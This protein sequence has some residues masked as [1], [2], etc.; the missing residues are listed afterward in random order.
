MGSFACTSTTNDASPAKGPSGPPIGADQVGGACSNVGTSPGDVVAFEHE[1]CPAGLCVADARDGFTSYCTADCSK[2]ACPEGYAC[3]AETLGDGRK[4]CLK[5]GSPAPGTDAGKDAAKADAG[6]IGTKN[7]KGTK[8]VDA[9][10]STKGTYTCDG[11]CQKAG[12]KCNEK[13]AGNGVGW[14][15]RKYNTG[16]GSFG[17][18]ISLCDEPESYT[19]GNTTITELYCFCDDMPVPPTVKVT[20]ADGLYTCATV[21]ASWSL[22]CSATRKSYAYADAKETTSPVTLGC[23]ETASASTDHYVCACD[24]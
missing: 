3:E 9:D 16:G 20:K 12:G 14:V 2:S 11:I 6:P 4:I 15:D 22:K 13:N 8:R 7:D 10:L 19:S 24:P 5:D 21:C 23:S 18:R 17:N 1:D